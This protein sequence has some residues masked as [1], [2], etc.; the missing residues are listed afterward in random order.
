MKRI[1]VSVTND[2]FSD[3]RVDKVCNSL[4][5]MGFD[6]LLVGRRYNNSPALSPRKYKTKRLHLLFKKGAAFYAEYNLRLFFHL[7]F[8]KCDILVANDL[9][10]LL[11]NY[12]AS[13]VRRK[14]LVYDSHEYFCEVPELVNRP[15]V[16]KFW[17]R[18]EQ[19]CFPKLKD[20]TTV[21]QSIADIYDKEYPRENKVKVV[22]NVPLK[23]MPAIT[24][25]RE[26]L[27]L[28]TDKRIIVMQGA[29]N[30]DRGAEE[31]ISAMQWI[32]N[33]LLLI[34]GNGD[35]IAELKE[36]TQ[37]LN[38]NERVRFIERQ[39]YHKL[40]NYTYLANVGCSLEKDT[41]INYRYC[42]PNKLFDYIRANIPVVVS[43]LPEMAKIVRDNNI[44]LVIAEHTPQAIADSINK[45]L[46]DSE[47]YNQCKANEAKASELYCW[48]NEEQILRDIY[49]A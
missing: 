24:E 17:R 26:S 45:L 28:P 27:N 31:L 18:I 5:E 25:T 14:K 3:N 11:A 2:L 12:M 41:N 7:L 15:R 29:I 22:K 34:I 13:R 44:G 49:L 38:M 30:L 1:I 33:A 35:K 36:L 46:N 4:T 9:D 39:P 32:D 47:L 10:T 43:N 21:C 6:V 48:E 42:L 19:H 40:F 20:V 16:Q 37:T 23:S 8:H